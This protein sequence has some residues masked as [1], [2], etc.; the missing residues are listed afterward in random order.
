MEKLEQIVIRREGG[1]MGFRVFKGFQK[2][3]KW[4]A[5]LEKVISKNQ[6]SVK[7]VGWVHMTD[8]IWGWRERFLMDE[9][10]N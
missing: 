3:E 4:L 5:I 1:V 6:T 8:E 7:S 2:I 9:K 10:Y